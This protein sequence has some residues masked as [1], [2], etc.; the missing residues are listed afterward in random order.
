MQDNGIPNFI[1]FI[2]SAAVLGMFILTAAIVGVLL[3]LAS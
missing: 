1:V 2:A 3:M